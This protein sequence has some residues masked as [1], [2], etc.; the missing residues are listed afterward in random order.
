MNVTVLGGAAAGG[1]TGSGCSGYLV[2]SAETNL[3]V[4]LGP[5]TLPELRKHCD[6]RAIDAIVITHWHVDHYLDLAALR[7]AAAYNPRPLEVQISLYMPP[8]A[9]QLL[10][11]FGSSLPL[12]EPD[13]GFF[14][15]CFAIHEF[16][17]EAT[18]SIGGLSCR[19]H[20]TKHYVP[21]WAVR[22]SEQSGAEVGYTADTGPGAA[23]ER[24]FRGV[25]V[26][27]A[28]ST[29]LDRDPDAVEPGHLTANEAGMLASVCSARTLVLTHMWEEFGFDNYLMR[30]RESFDGEIV[31]ATPGLQ[32]SAGGAR[33]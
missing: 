23:L 31:L 29:E 17:P 33:A 12:D 3:V 6:F 26:L 22:I 8:G 32:V 18:I 27:I 5:G 28:E 11:R 1:N 4:D 20:P 25:H 9:A 14:D 2:Q 10:R 16:D 19:F 15:E 24:F 21:C 30:A 13:Y 7:F